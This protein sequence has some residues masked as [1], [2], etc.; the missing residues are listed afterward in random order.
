M[1][2]P[3]SSLQRIISL[4][5]AA[6]EMVALLGADDR[7][8]GRSHECDVPDNVRTLP[9][10]CQTRVNADASSGF[11]H[12]MVGETLA[13]G[14]SLYQLDAARI[15]ELQP[16]LLI[17]QGQCEVC[18]VS[19]A[20]LESLWAEWAGPRPAILSLNPTSLDD[21]WEDLRR[22]G[23]WLG[24]SSKAELELQLLQA[25]VTAVQ[26]AGRSL[27]HRQGVLGLEWFD[28]LMAAGNWF[29]EMARIAG[30]EAVLAE[31]GRHSGWIEWEQVRECDPEMLLLLPCGFDMD[32]VVREAETLKTLPGWEDLQAVRESRV[33]ATDG[34]Q[35]FNRPGPRLVDSLE[36][37]SEL[38]QGVSAS[39]SRS[40]AR[41]QR[42]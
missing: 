4:L 28:P 14:Q 16:D 3:D 17:V 21:L 6:T 40:P 33:F 35:Y 19:E 37:L 9:V 18:A 42:I 25:R 23:E 8:V 22:L 12:E 10:C 39:Q 41:W 26:T 32:R 27:R 7:L 24:E 5:P 11:I 2:R 13:Q 34:N 38:L 20:D 30:G 29:P 15:R 31:A 36:I 1:S